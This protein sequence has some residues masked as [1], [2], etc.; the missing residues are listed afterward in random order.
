MCYSTVFLV[1]INIAPQNNGCGAREILK[2]LP[3][4]FREIWHILKTLP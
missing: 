2:L 1:C 4:I 3:R